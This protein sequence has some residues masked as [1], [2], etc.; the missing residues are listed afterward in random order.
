MGK[1]SWIFPSQIQFTKKIEQIYVYTYLYHFGRT[2]NFMSITFSPNVVKLLE[3]IKNL[4]CS[5][6]VLVDR[7]HSYMSLDVS[8]P[9]IPRDFL[10][11]VVDIINQQMFLIS[12]AALLLCANNLIKSSQSSCHTLRHNIEWQ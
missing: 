6:L 8:N 4:L 1:K 5:K 7:Y 9:C 2:D 3:M 12:F 11:V 10:V